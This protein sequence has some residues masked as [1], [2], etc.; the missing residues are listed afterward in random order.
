MNT[1]D[2]D[3]HPD[4]SHRFCKVL[5]ISATETSGRKSDVAKQTNNSTEFDSYNDSI[6]ILQQTARVAA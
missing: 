6:L 3:G 2:S 4:F 1:F 5:I